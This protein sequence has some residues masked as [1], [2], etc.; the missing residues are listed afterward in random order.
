TAALWRAEQRAQGAAI[1]PADTAGMGALR[2]SGRLVD[3][4][5]AAIETLLKL[6]F[7]G[8]LHDPSVADSLAFHIPDD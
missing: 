5:P 7:R 2:S 4:E 6:S 3:G 1:E 8:Q